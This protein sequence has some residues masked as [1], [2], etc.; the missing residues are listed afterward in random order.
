V[1]FALN[2][3]LTIGFSEATSMQDNVYF[4]IFFPQGFF[5]GTIMTLY[6]IAFSYF[7]HRVSG[8]FAQA[9]IYTSSYFSHWV[10]Q[11]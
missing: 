1:S 2:N 9:F 7:S 5:M 3:F 10:F 8:V 4:F 11:R 6:A